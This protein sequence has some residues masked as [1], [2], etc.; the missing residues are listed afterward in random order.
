MMQ[1]LVTQTQLG[2]L[3]VPGSE[4]QKRAGR[5]MSTPNVVPIHIQGW[6]IMKPV[7]AMSIAVSFIKAE[8]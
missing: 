7:M 6:L 4:H 3:W 2:Q 1:F 8:Q 5:G